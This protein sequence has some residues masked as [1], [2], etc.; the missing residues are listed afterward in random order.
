MRTH[1]PLAGKKDARIGWVQ[2]C[3]RWALSMTCTPQ[4]RL[5]LICPFAPPVQRLL[6][7][8]RLWDLPVLTH[9]VPFTENSS[10][11]THIPA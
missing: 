6:A 4:A 1:D 5:P 11:Y 3:L 10:P 9:T 7:T 2:I 8:P